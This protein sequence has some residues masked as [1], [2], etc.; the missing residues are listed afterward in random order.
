MDHILI[1]SAQFYRQRPA[2]NRLLNQISGAQERFSRALGRAAVASLRWPEADSPWA[3]RSS[4]QRG[5]MISLPVKNQSITSRFVFVRRA[6]LR[7]SGDGRPSEPILA[8]NIRS[9][10][11]R[12]ITIIGA[13]PWLLSIPNETKAPELFVVFNELSAGHREVFNLLL[14]VGPA[15]Y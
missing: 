12:V 11:V 3:G 9:A 8:A 7:L 15:Y 5:A 1:S 14:I 2:P 6:G 10:R 4:P 13:W